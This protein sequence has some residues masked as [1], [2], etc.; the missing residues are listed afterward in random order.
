LSNALVD[1]VGP[2][3]QGLN[4]EPLTPKPEV[5]NYASVASPFTQLQGQSS[6]V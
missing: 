6:S 1:G 2:K 5:L 3:V 4:S